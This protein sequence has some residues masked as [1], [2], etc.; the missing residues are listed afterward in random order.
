MELLQ[1]VVVLWLGYLIAYLNILWFT[2][3]A[4]F[5]F[6]GCC[7]CEACRAKRQTLDIEESCVL[8]DLNQVSN[9][10]VR[11]ERHHK[12]HIR[13]MIMLSLLLS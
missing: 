10:N 7:K 4:P 6:D 12:Y 5:F 11:S 2:C 1:W 8:V 13:L 3:S 9:F